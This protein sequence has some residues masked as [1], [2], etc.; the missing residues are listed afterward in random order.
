MGLQYPPTGSLCYGYS[1]RAPRTSWNTCQTGRCLG[2]SPDLL[3][4]CISPRSLWTSS[5]R[6]MGKPDRWGRP[7]F[8][9]SPSPQEPEP[10]RPKGSIQQAQ[11]VR[12]SCRCRNSC[13]ALKHLGFCSFPKPST[14]PKGPLPVGSAP[15]LFTLLIQGPCH[16]STIIPFL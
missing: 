7:D 15:G 10:C 11:T 4:I 6:G 1:N 16:V 8:L 12:G 14:F 3:G 13:S 5:L 9:N 2:P